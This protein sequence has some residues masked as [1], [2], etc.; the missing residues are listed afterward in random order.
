[1]TKSLILVR[2]AQSINLQQGIKD[3]ERSLTDTGV[4][5]A[6][7]IGKYLNNTKLRPDLIYTSNAERAVSTAKL[8]AEQTGNEDHEIIMLDDLYEASFRILL[9]I[10]NQLENKYN[11]VLIIGHNPAISFLC[12]FLSDHAIGEIVPAGI[13]ILKFNDMDWET[14]GKA[15]GQIFEYISPS[16]INL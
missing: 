4:Q 3:I 14:I 10:I 2:H 15:S 1:M 11:N 9:K 6:Y 12:E 5:E 13:C 8:I 7:K 16:E